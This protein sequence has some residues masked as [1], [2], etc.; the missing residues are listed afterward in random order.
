MF[1][2]DYWFR[3]AGLLSLN[4]VVIKIVI[5]DCYYPGSG[6]PRTSRPGYVPGADEPSKFCVRSMFFIVFDKQLI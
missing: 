5:S 3:L 6:N 4:S 2:C 1:F